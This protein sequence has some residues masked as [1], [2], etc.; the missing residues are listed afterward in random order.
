MSTAILE[1]QIIRYYDDCH[2]GLQATGHVNSHFSMHCGYWSKQTANYKEALTNLDRKVAKVAGI[3]RKDLVLDAGCGIGG[4][5][6]Y[7]AKNHNCRVE[8]ITLSEKQ[9]QFA[10]QMAAGHNLNDRVQFSV[11]N[12]NQ[13]NFPDE[14]FDVVWAIESVCHAQEKLAFLQEAYRLLKPKG[15]LV[16]ADFFG[17]SGASGDKN[18]WMQKWAD[19]VAIPRFESLPDF[20]DK[21]GKA[22]FRRITSSNITENITPSSRSL[23]LQYL[24][25]F[26]GQSVLS[27]IDSGRNQLNSKEKAAFYQYRALKLDLWNYH[28]VWARKSK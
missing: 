8:G 19:C 6:I 12:F 25:G 17:N 21:A 22:G 10:R 20:L 13:T 24:P 7:L 16:V 9:V 2:R 18:K 1:E 27:L 26:I 3:K 15:R 5:A 4:S 11:G 14:T 23:Y 28:L